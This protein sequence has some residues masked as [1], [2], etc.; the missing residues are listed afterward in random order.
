MK[1]IIHRGANE[2]GGSC[3]E[4][5]TKNTR[6]LVDFG[7]PLQFN[8]EKFDSQTLQGEPIKALREAGILPKIDGLYQDQP[9]SINA[10]LVSHSHLDHYGLLNY[11]NQDIPVYLSKGAKALI[12]I[13]NIFLPQKTGVINDRVMAP[14][15]PVIINDLTVTPFAVDHSAF[16]ALAFLIEA[17]GKRVFYSGDFRG[18]GRKSWLFSQMVERPLKDINCLLLEGTTVGRNQQDFKDEQSA[19]RRITEILKEQKNITFLFASSQNIDRIVSAYKACLR[20]GSLFVI[21]IYTALILSKLSKISKNLPQYDWKN[22]RVKFYHH[23]VKR[24]KEANLGNLLFVYDK[25]KID[26]FEISRKKRKILMLSRD[27]SIFP[28]LVKSIGD[29]SGGKVIYSMWEGYLTDK[30]RWFCEETGLELE[31]VH[32]G[33]HAGLDDLKTFAAALNTETLVPIH[34]FNKQRFKELFNNVKVLDDK[35]CL[36][37]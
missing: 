29:V 5:T 18:H 7:L 17:E 34:T 31:T 13:S 1:L 8:K 4:I 25:R 37:I 30:F 24:L 21:D 6:V 2:I 19:E 11:V 3:V 33:G 16:D 27:N 9:Q 10:I 28:A 32:A 22:V 15:K 14:K 26:K 20:T 23:H 35:E 36:E 12:E